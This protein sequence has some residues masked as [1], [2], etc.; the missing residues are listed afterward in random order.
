MGESFSGWKRKVGLLT[1]VL[2]CVFLGFWVRSRILIDYIETPIGKHTSV[3][4]V[5]HD[6]FFALFAEFDPEFDLS[7]SSAKWLSQ[8]TSKFTAEDFVEMNYGSIH[9]MIKY[10][11]HP[12]VVPKGPNQPIRVPRLSQ[13]HWLIGL[14]FMYLLTIPLTLISLWLLLSK[15]RKSTPMKPA[16]A[17]LVDGA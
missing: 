8:S 7:S 13:G 17:P 2:A 5:T 10:R 1:L 14:P 16:E 12:A 6:Q 15:H 9:S 4:L 11:N 3:L